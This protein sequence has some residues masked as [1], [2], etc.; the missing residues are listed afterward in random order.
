MGKFSVIFDRSGP[1]CVGGIFH[2]REKTKADVLSINRYGCSPFVRQFEPVHA[3]ITRFIGLLKGTVPSILPV[4]CFTQIPNAIVQLIVV[5]VIQHFRWPSS[6]NIEPR[7]PVRVDI[8]SIEADY[9]IA[10]R[11]NGTCSLSRNVTIFSPREYSR[12]WIVIQRFQKRFVSEFF[13]PWRIA[14]ESGDFSAF[15]ECFRFFRGMLNADNSRRFRLQVIPADPLEQSRY[16]TNATRGRS[17]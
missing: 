2:V 1:I 13:H 3:F 5:D 7:Q 9:R 16:H 17:S 4:T 11:I 15:N 10:D 6:M 14:N 12:F 8:G